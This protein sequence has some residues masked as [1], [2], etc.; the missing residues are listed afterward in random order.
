M[1]RRGKMIRVN[2]EEVNILETNL[3]QVLLELGY[4][5]DRVVVELNGDIVRRDDRVKV[6]LKDGDVLE[7]VS[8]VGGG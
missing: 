2:G 8:F 7:V 3:E 4:R 6:T 5:T 1:E